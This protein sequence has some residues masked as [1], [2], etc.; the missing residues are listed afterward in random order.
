LVVGVLPATSR[1]VPSQAQELQSTGPKSVLVVSISGYDAVK[2]DVQAIAQ[3]SG[4]R[5]LMAPVMLAGR[6]GPAGRDTTRPWGAVAQT[7]GQKLRAFAFLPAKELEPILALLSPLSGGQGLPEPDADGVYEIEVRNRELVLAQKGDWAILADDRK[8]L[9]DVPDDPVPLLEGLNESYLFA[10]RAEVKNIPDDWRAQAINLLRLGVQM[11]QQPAP[12]ES[13]EQRAMRQRTIA[14]SMEEMERFVN[15]T[16]TVLVGLAVDRE[17]KAI[18][19]DMEIT[20]VEGTSAAAEYALSADAKSDLAGFYVPEA[21]LTALFAGTLPE[22][23]AAQLEDM[24]DTRASK[25]MQDL[26]EQALSDEERKLAKQILGDL[27]GVMRETVQ[28]RRVDAGLAVLAD[29]DS[30]NLVGGGFVADTATLEK[31]FKQMVHLALAED[32]DLDE[33]ITLDADEHQGVRLHTLSVPAEQLPTDDIPPML[34]GESLTAAVGFSDRHVYVALGPQAIDKLR[35]AIDQSKAAAGESVPAFRLSLSATGIRHVVEGASAATE[36][37]VPP[38]ILDALRATGQNDHLLI[39]SEAISNG[40]RQQLKVEAGALKV[41][42]AAVGAAMSRFGPGAG[43]FPG[44]PGAF[45][46][47]PRGAP[48]QPRF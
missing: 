1:V 19:L 37:D 9:A 34:V 6:E 44:Q 21:A 36:T 45:P 27:V 7:V 17:S 5:E 31:V 41:I 13:P 35:Q 32:P 11:G 40:V 22:S 38:E 24:I 26:D 43:G 10:I 33:A 39:L 15:E 25:A 23:D 47:Q 20:A 48:G 18:R 4:V 2:D 30:L 8:T 29:A 42:G 28:G 3:A 46:G 16:D 14:R 12:D